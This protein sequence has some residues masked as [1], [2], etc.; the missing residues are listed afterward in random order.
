MWE[1]NEWGCTPTTASTKEKRAN[2][3]TGRGNGEKLL[4]RKQEGANILYIKGRISMEQG[5]RTPPPSDSY[6]GCCRGSWHCNILIC[7]YLQ[8][9]TVRYRSSFNVWRP[10]INEDR[11]NSLIRS[12]SRRWHA[13]RLARV[14][15]SKPWKSNNH[16]FNYR[17]LSSAILPPLLG[18]P[19]CYRVQGKTTAKTR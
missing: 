9:A 7:I 15:P 1:D 4:G 11:R 3:A 2:E 14:S 18:S 6:F 12:M 5:T 10:K 17:N 16:Q 13:F 19:Q 8:V